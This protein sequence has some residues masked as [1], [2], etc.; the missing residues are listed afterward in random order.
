MNRKLLRTMSA[1]SASAT[2]FALLLLAG[3][4]LS[5]PTPGDGHVPIATLA[6]GSV[7][8]DDAGLALPA[9][10]AVEA[11]DSA[12]APASTS[13]HRGAHRARALLALPYFSFAQG[14]RR[15][16]S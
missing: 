7:L 12:G 14:L 2:V 10:E 11:P 1:L 4:P 8:A 6:P 15:S 3:R 5:I 9:D 13:R 16:R